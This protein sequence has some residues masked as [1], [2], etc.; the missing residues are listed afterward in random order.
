MKIG[1]I[2]YLTD[3]RNYGQRLQ[4][5]ALQRYIKL[6]F[7]LDVATLDGR[8]VADL[9][10]GKYFH[11]FE[12]ECMN[13]VSAYREGV[14][15]EFDKIIVGGDQVLDGR[16]IGRGTTMLR[17]KK[18]GRRNVFTYGAGIGSGCRL[19]QKVRDILWPHLICYG[20]RERCSD[21][22]YTPNIDP[23]FLMHDK[24]DEVGRG[25]WERGGVVTYKG[26][27]TSAT[28]RKR[29]APIMPC[30]IDDSCRSATCNRNAESIKILDP[31]FG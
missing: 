22:D 30:M 18:V 11:L 6:E 12:K 13:L 9:G 5:Y 28:L 25:V 24:W 3:D 20:I 2:T 4:A 21:L 7:G 19:D 10:D 23:V 15:D 1:N 26:I 8:G 17:T 27:V 29:I 16:G 14:I 31:A